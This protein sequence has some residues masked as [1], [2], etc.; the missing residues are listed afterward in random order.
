MA[1]GDHFRAVPTSVEPHRA[2]P[3]APDEVGDGVAERSLQPG[4][5]REHRAAA[6]VSE[7]AF[8]EGALARGQAA[9]G[10]A[11]MV[12]GTESAGPKSEAAQPP[13]DCM[14]GPP[15]ERAEHGGI[16]GGVEAEQFVFVCGPA[17]AGA[18]VGAPLR[19]RACAHGGG[20]PLGCG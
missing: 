13:D 17:G 19:A 16:Q 2:R 9:V 11:W 4:L 6:L 10:G 20:L 7:L 14:I 1:T 12:G 5:E 3:R 8:D 18:P 15:Q